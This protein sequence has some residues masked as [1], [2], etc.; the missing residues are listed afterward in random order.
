MRRFDP[1][2]SLPAYP[3]APPLAVP[4]DEERAR[5]L[6]RAYRRLFAIHEIE[7]SPPLRWLCVALLV[8]FFQTF[9]DWAHDS[10]VTA[11]TAAHGS[12]QCWPYFQGCGKWYVLDAL[13]RAYSQ[14]TLY[15]LA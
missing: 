5:P 8:A 10:F 13:P 3:E 6:L 15:A 11:R 2:A 1:F 7:A 14:T 9:H 12:H 4:L